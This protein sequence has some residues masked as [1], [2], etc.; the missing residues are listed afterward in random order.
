MNSV[1]K[2]IAP[3]NLTYELLNTHL[4][5]NIEEYKTLGYNINIIAD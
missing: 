5:D 3:M 2:L 1:D 4:Y